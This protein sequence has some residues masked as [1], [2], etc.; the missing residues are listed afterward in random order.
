MIINHIRSPN[1]TLM[2]FTMG[3][4]LFVTSTFRGEVTYGPNKGPCVYR[5]GQMVA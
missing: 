2:D 4:I 1:F 3:N 5:S